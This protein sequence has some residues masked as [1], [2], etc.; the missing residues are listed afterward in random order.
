MII[1]SQNSLLDIELSVAHES[2]VQNYA[3]RIIASHGSKDTVLPASTFHAI[4][5]IINKQIKLTDTHN[6]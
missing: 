2:L 4:D 3:A 1:R 6:F 5:P